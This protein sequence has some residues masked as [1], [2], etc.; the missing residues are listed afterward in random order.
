[1]YLLLSETDWTHIENILL[2]AGVVIV[3]LMLIIAWI[4]GE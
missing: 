4:M 2:G 3:I 1:M